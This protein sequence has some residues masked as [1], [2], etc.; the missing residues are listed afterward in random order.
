MLARVRIIAG[1]GA[2]IADKGNDNAGK[3]SAGVD[4][5]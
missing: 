1:K 3:G 4:S 5:L 2:K